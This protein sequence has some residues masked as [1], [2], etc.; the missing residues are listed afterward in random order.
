MPVLRETM[1]AQ[2]VQVILEDYL[3]LAAV[4]VAL[5]EQLL[6]TTKAEQAEH[7]L[8]P[9]RLLSLVPLACLP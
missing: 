2:V 9:E 7:V 3:V 8:L 6:S 5:A 4:V 1:V